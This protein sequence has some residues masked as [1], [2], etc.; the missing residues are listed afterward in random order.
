M[1]VHVMVYEDEDD[2]YD[3]QRSIATTI[4]NKTL[5]L[6]LAQLLAQELDSMLVGLV[7]YFHFFRP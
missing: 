5:P 2:G 7:C 3:D 1:K 6:S 4:K